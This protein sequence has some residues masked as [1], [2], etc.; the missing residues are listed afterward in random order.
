MTTGARL[1]L[2]LRALEERIPPNGGHHAIHYAKYGSDV[3]GWEDRLALT[4][5]LNNPNDTIGFQ[6]LFFDEADLDRPIED[7]VNEVAGLIDPTKARPDPTK[8]TPTVVSPRYWTRS[9]L[10]GFVL[11]RLWVWYDARGLSHGRSY[12]CVNLEATRDLLKLP[13][14]PDRDRVSDNE[15]LGE[16]RRRQVEQVA[17]G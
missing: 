2:L 14:H 9:E 4:I 10:A 3:L 16:I 1:L 11:W 17:N 15:V 6:T 7:L 12:E 8:A 13:L 5:R